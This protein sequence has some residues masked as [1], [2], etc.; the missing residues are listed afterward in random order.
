MELN[1][2]IEKTGEILDAAGVAIIA[3]GIVWAFLRSVGLGR[4]D[5]SNFVS[6]RRNIG[7]AI[8]L[9]L[10][11]LIAADIVRTVAVHPTFESLG[12]LAII[13]AIRIAL[14][15]ELELE[16]SSRWPWQK[17]TEA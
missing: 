4:G 14:S 1:E 8:L 7:R 2:T 5:A 10:E 11:V 9:G 13:V 17:E 16:I 6:L 12:I 3:I 15:T